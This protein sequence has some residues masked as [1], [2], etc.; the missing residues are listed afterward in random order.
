MSDLYH[1]SECNYTNVNLAGPHWLLKKDENKNLKEDYDEQ[2]TGQ[3]GEQEPR[4]GK[5]HKLHWSWRTFLRPHHP[6]LMR[7]APC[8]QPHSPLTLPHSR[9][10]H[11]AAFIIPNT[12][13]QKKLCSQCH[14]NHAAAFT[15]HSTCIMMLPHSL[16][17][18]A[19]HLCIRIYAAAL[20]PH[21]CC[22]SHATLHIYTATFTLFIVIFV[23]CSL[24]M[25]CI[26]IVHCDHCFLFLFNCYTYHCSLLSRSLCSIIY[27]TCL[28]VF[29][30]LTILCCP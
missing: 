6:V 9:I 29:L 12:F 7:C 21:L 28:S 11:A 19:V 16:Q 26:V 1:F 13:M 27:T 17:F 23:C 18:R 2:L 3:V 22:W 15:L 5:F 30:L 24:F 10:F 14:R 4:Q 20:T 25:W 8:T